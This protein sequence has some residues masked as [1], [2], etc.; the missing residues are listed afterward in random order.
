MTLKGLCSPGRR[1]PA[2][3]DNQAV[4]L[5]GEEGDNAAAGG[6][7][8]HRRLLLQGG[9]TFAAVT[10]APSEPRAAA[11]PIDLAAPP[12]IRT[13]GAPFSNY[14]QPSPHE[15]ALI[16]SIGANH[17][18][19][20][21]GVSWTPLGEL[22][23]TIT[24]SGLHF[25]RHHNGV[26]AIDPALH[27]LVI[28]GRV[29]RAL[30]FTV[31]SLARYPMVTKTLA[32]ECG[33]NSNAGWH[34]EPI[35]RRVGD[36]HGLVSCS[37][38]TG[39]P[40]NILLDEAGVDPAATWAVAEGADAM[41]MNVSLPM[42]K[43][44]DDCLVALYQNGE[45]IRPENGYPLR[46]IAPGW[47][48]VVN[49]KWLRRL[50]ITDQPVMARNETAKYTELLP[51]GRA[52]MFSFV[53]GVKSLITSPS[54]KQELSGPGLYEIKG[55]AWSGQGRIRKVDVSA[56]GGLSWTE[57]AL[58]EPVL[59][60]A[61]TRFR[62]PWRWSGAQAVLKSRAT[63][64]AGNVQP[65]RT[66]LVAERGRNGYFHYNAIVAW[67]VDTDGTVSHVYA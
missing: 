18:L 54:C 45:R 48:G 37:E 1:I 4:P 55:L 64:E 53:I 59:P 46:L 47:E 57:A 33:G 22:E 19:S 60:H 58:Q 29:R 50:E 39:V 62:A 32:I 9:L 10:A 44:M 35:Q 2:D 36:F 11:P 23:G 38:W 66:A 27:R 15:A 3:R 56:D 49:V 20:G 63:D 34:L 67:A 28:H 6:G 61:F 30:M 43:L 8:I 21:N 14:G 51:S 13:P 5:S 42:A 12:W 40:L 16:R 26:P 52:R 41:L 25:E 31:D 17:D 24:P 65:E 7:L